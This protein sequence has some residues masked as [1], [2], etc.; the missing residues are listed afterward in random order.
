MSLIYHLAPAS[1]WSSW[2]KGEPYLPADYEREGFIHCTSGDELMLKVANEFYRTV[3]GDFVLL[4]LDTDKLK[5]PPSE[6]KWEKST[7]FDPLF[8]HIYGPI[9]QHAV[10]D[11]RTFQRANDG[12]F[13]GWTKA[14]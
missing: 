10:T 14:N 11:V 13:L 2:P 4:V 6:V 9:D 5:N 1:R 7:V 8:P 3:P 12:T